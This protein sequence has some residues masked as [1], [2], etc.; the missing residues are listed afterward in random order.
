VRLGNQR[1]NSRARPCSLALPTLC[2]ALLL[3]VTATAA[4][5]SVGH[6]TA[7]V[8][9]AELQHKWGRVWELMHPRQRAFI[10]RALFVHCMSK[11]RNAR[12]RTIHVLSV[13][14][15]LASIPGV[16]GP[17]VSVSTVQLR[18]DYGKAAPSQQQ[19][20]RA[21]RVGGTWYWINSASSTRA[22]RRIN[23]CR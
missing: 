11:V 23:F 6:F 19:A 21:A 22:F 14:R 9:T 15:G 13:R 8:E 2:L 20:V 10:P 17:R 7:R 4:G 3:P 16:P 1:M 12:P 18:I 5:E